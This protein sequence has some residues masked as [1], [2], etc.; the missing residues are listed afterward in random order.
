[1]VRSAW[2]RDEFLCGQSATSGYRARMASL[3]MEDRTFALSEQSLDGSSGQLA[4]VGDELCVWAGQTRRTCRVVRRM[5]ETFVCKGGEEVE[6]ARTHRR[7]RWVT[8]P[9]G[10]QITS[11]SP[12]PY[13]PSQLPSAPHL[14]PLRTAS[15]TIQHD[16]SQGRHQRVRSNRPRRSQARY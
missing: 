11:S 7:S 3:T 13:K 5:S 8:H 9:D 12:P 1:M 2:T 14:P 15:K 10:S 16:S 4:A 6:Q